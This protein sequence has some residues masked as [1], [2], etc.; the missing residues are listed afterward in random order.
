[1]SY[2][3]VRPAGYTLLWQDTFDKPILDES[4]WNKELRD[5]GWT[6]NELQAYTASTENI[7]IRDG[8]LV[9]K[10]L[11]TVDAAG[12]VYYTSGKVTTQHKKDFTYGRVEIC[13]KVPRGRGLWPAAWLMPTEEMH[14]GQWP[15]C[16]EIDIMEVLGHDVHTT[17][18][19]IHYG[20]PHMQQQGQ[21]RLTGGSLADDFHTYSVEW[22]PKTMRFYFDNQK[23]LT[24]D[25]W[26]SANAER[27]LPYPA[28]FDQPFF[29]QLNLAVGGDWP[30]SPD[31]STDF[32]HAE[33]IIDSVRVYQKKEGN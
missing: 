31:Q 26:Y 5:P 29:V 23:I 17:Y 18:S 4:I 33:F 9:L 32:T 12:R 28:P 1:M 3:I 20:K 30:G 13:A 7:F 24:V 19:T 16:G 8:K 25:S 27:R 2:E 11:R 14:Y 6:N 10:A 15:E 21:L 22:E